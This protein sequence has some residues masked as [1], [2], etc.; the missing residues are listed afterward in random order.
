MTTNLAIEIIAVRLSSLDWFVTHNQG[1]KYLFDDDRKMA[2]NANDNKQDDG[3]DS[4]KQ[5]AAEPMEP[6]PELSRPTMSSAKVRRTQDRKRSRS[7][8]TIHNRGQ[9]RGQ[10]V[11]QNLANVRI[12]QPTYRM[13]SKNPF[14]VEHVEFV[15]ERCTKENVSEYMPVYR[16]DDATKFAKELSQ[17][18]RFR[19]KLQH[20]DRYRLIIF[21]NVAEKQYQSVC[22]QVGFLWDHE[23]DLWTYF[24]HETKTFIVTVAVFGVYWD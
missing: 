22:M 15:V 11:Y 13:V 18:I 8:Y 10:S 24:R 2:E 6:K 9:S 14:N 4:G 23:N 3:N 20:F 19:I 16:G 17:E 7:R 1:D 5:V 21:V 12:Y